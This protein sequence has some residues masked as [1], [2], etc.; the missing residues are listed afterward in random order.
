MVSKSFIV[1]RCIAIV[2][3]GLFLSGMGDAPPLVEGQAPPFE[4]ETADGKVVKLSD[5][6][7]KFIVLNFWATWCVPC[8]KELPEFQKA[9]QSLKDSNVEIIGINL[10]ESGDKV[11]KY[12]HDHQLSFPVLLDSYGNVSAKYRIIGVPTTFFINPDGI[13]LGK[14]FGGGIT[15]EMIE[16]KINQLLS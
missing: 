10:A 7:G 8:Y 4:L 5:L 6:K 9:H 1:A 16:A 15:K 11:N 3:S 2:L 12:M 13:I 14:I